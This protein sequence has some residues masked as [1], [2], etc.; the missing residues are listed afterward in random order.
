MK[1]ETAAVSASVHVL[2]GALLGALAMF[3][4]SDTSLVTLDVS[5]VDVRTKLIDDEAVPDEGYATHLEAVIAASDRYNPDSI[6]HNREHV[7]GILRCDG[8]YFYTHGLGGE[9]Q[10]PVRFSIVIPKSC[11]LAALWHTHGGEFPD[12]EYF[13]QADTRSAEKT[14]KPMF[15]TNHTGRLHVYHPGGSRT[16]RLIPGSLQR[17]PRGASV[18]ELLRTEL[19]AAIRIATR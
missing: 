16:G 5:H 4:L 1:T 9:G 8:R 17:L 18:G 3:L 14:G 19:G 6:R 10:A 7:G 15:M 13:S 11:A 2:R 12:R